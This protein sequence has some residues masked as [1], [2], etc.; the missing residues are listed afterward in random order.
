MKAFSTLRALLT[1]GALAA[2]LA[3]AVPATLENSVR[4][5]S[6]ARRN[7]RLDAAELRADLLGALYAGRIDEIRRLIPEHE[8]YFLIDGGTP[9]DSEPLWVRYELAPRRALLVGPLDE[10]RPRHLRLIRRHALPWVVIAYPSGTP[11]RALPRQRFL[12]EMS[13]QL[14]R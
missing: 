6:L 8:A 5:F 12:E 13:G 2:F 14:A 11:P 3:T 10:L 9:E 1:V 4:L 7:A